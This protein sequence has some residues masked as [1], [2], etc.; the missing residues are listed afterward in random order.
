MSELCSSVTIHQAFFNISFSRYVVSNI[1]IVHCGSVFFIIGFVY[2]I[3]IA[4]GWFIRVW[5]LGPL[6]K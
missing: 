2:V 3:D 4:P 6:K 5:W 1:V